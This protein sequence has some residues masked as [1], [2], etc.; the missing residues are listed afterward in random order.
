MMRR[1]GATAREVKPKQEAVW[2]QK[3]SVFPLN[4]VSLKGGR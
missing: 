3:A 4:A 2:S 1:D